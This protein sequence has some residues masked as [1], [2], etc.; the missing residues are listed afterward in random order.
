MATYI[1]FNIGSVNGLLPDGT[2]PL[3]K[4]MLTSHYWGAVAFIWEQFCKRRISY[5][6]L[7]L[8]WN[9]LS[10]SKFSVEFPRGQSVKQEEDCWCEISVAS[11]AGL[12]L[13][14]YYWHWDVVGNC[15]RWCC[16]FSDWLH[17]GTA[18]LRSQLWCWGHLYGCIYILGGF[19]PEQFHV[20]C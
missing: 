8:D 20:D 15:I 3:P 6:S 16:G 7:K 4:P 13:S 18:E 1:W 12:G 14:D 11:I 19:L 2:K 10:K 5:Q 17:R 9:Y